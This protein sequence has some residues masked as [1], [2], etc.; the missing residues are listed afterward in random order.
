MQGVLDTEA[1]SGATASDKVLLR[2]MQQVGE[3][4]YLTNAGSTYLCERIWHEHYPSN[5]MTCSQI[6]HYKW[7]NRTKCPNP[8]CGDIQ[9]RV[10]GG[11][12]RGNRT[13]RH[14]DQHQESEEDEDP[15]ASSNG[16]RDDE[17][18]DDSAVSIDE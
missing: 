12:K 14:T 11:S 8:R 9:S 15:P 6:W 7:E 10:S 2:S 5:A 4:S 13:S 3:S 1:Q 18:E 17:I 16:G